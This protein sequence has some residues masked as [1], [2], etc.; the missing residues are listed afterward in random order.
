MKKNFIF[1]LFFLFSTTIFGEVLDLKQ[2]IEESLIQSEKIKAQKFEEEIASSEKKEVFW[3]FFPTT[4]ID[5]S[6]MKYKFSPEPKPM[7]FPIGPMLIPVFKTL[8]F[9]VDPKKLLAVPP[10]EIPADLPTKNR[11]LDIKIVQPITPLWSVYN[12]FKAKK[13]VEK[14]RKLQKQLSEEEIKKKVSEMFY[15]YQLLE[16]VKKTLFDAKKQLDLYHKQAENFISQGMADKRAVLK[17]E[18]EQSK[19]EKSLEQVRGSE[20]V[21]KTGLALFMNKDKNSFSLRKID[22]NVENIG[23]SLSDLLENQKKFRKEFAI[24]DEMKNVSKNAK[25]VAMQDLIPTVGIVGGYKKTW[26]PMPFSP[27]GTFFVGG[28]ISWKIGFDWIVNWNK[29]ENAKMVEA[30]T[31]LENIDKK[32]MMILQVTK[33]FSDLNVKLKEI[34]IA[35]KQIESAKENLRIEETKYKQNMT[36]E[37]DL[38]KANLDLRQAK[39]AFLSA[40]Y[41]FKIAKINLELT[42][43]MSDK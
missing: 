8:G 19:I 14:I 21:I 26:D 10:V 13:G 5:F 17:I 9:P 22:V 3:K 20:E 31:N 2:C 28:V 15:T 25:Y 11:E 38:L 35:K 34:D 43:G 32:K 27:G 37:T 30:K 6:L 16:S 40:V 29:Y 18:I 42:V 33:M 23:F 7:V 4:T 36:T 24:L 41:K 39:T 1:I 12:G